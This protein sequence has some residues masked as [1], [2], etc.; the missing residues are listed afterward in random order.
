MAST[1]EVSVVL[2]DAMLNHLRRQAAGL[3]VPIEFLVASLVCDTMDSF[4]ARPRREGA[5]GRDFR[6]GREHFQQTRKTLAAGP[7]VLSSSQ[8]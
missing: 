7:G 1:P 2:S 4:A 3:V 8:R 5:P 6:Q